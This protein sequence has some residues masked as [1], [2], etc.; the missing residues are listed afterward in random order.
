MGAQIDQ[1]PAQQTFF[2]FFK[3]DRFFNKLKLVKYEFTNYL[4]VSFSVTGDAE[5]GELLLDAQVS[6]THH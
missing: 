5:A 6:P 1:A 4:N 3:I 2:K